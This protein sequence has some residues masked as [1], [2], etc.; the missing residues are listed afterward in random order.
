MTSQ[1]RIEANRRNALKSTGPR[2]PEGRAR[3][4]QNARKHGLTARQPGCD[5][6]LIARL[7]Q[8]QKPESYGPLARQAIAAWAHATAHYLRTQAAVTRLFDSRLRVET[9]RPMTRRA[10]ERLGRQGQ[11]LL[12]RAASL[13]ADEDQAAQWLEMGRTN[14]RIA[15]DRDRAHEAFETGRLL[16]ALDRAETRALKQMRRADLHMVEA[17]VRDCV[18]FEWHICR[19][20]PDPDQE[21]KPSA[22][23]A[24]SNSADSWRLS[25][26][27][28]AAMGQKR[29]T[30]R[31]QDRL[32]IDNSRAAWRQDAATGQQTGAENQT[33]EAK[34]QEAACSERPHARPGADAALDDQPFS[35]P[36]QSDDPSDNAPWQIRRPADG[37][38]APNEAKPVAHAGSAIA[39]NKANIRADCRDKI[40]ADRHAASSP[41]RDRGG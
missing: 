16:R 26:S 31:Q 19:P 41:A 17:M 1:A 3:S 13:E 9:G 22:A 5:A 24:A 10:A 33:I 18:D 29:D 37:A 7:E 4:A 21:T 34:R 32:E 6:A 30:Y 12:C 8:S 36:A 27:A 39:P 38:D 15:L 2:T 11:R 28:A 23:A 40:G 35:A 14:I 20:R 25:A